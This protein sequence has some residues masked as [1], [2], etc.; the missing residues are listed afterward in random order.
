MIKIIIIIINLTANDY[1]SS[2][3]NDEFQVQDQ[4]EPCIIDT[5][6]ENMSSSSIT[7]MDLS[8]KQN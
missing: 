8:K 6:H 4:E 1:D 2:D 5:S 7:S 3:D